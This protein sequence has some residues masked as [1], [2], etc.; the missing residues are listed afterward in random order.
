MCTILWL[1]VD[2]NKDL[3]NSSI[4]ASAIDAIVVG[5]ML[6]P[7]VLNPISPATPLR[8]GMLPTML[9]AIV[10]HH[11]CRVGLLEKLGCTL[12]LNRSTRKHGDGRGARVLAKMMGEGD[13]HAGA[14]FASA[15]DKDGGAVRWLR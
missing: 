10:L 14:E 12:G 6:E 1:F 2:G 5:R 11:F 15:D 3:Y 13:Q 7:D 8:S 9:G 4:L